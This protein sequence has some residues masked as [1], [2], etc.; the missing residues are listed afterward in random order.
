MPEAIIDSEKKIKGEFIDKNRRRSNTLSKTV[1]DINL[2]D[3]SKKQL[4]KKLLDTKTVLPSLPAQSHDQDLD[5]SKE[6]LEDRKHHPNQLTGSS[7][8]VGV[9]VNTRKMI[10]KI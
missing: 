6:S 3:S 9:G 1:I 2:D 8:K 10:A 7:N 5:K 4:M